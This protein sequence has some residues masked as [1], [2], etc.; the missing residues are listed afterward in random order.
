[1]WLLCTPHLTE[2]YWWWFYDTVCYRKIFDVILWRVFKT[3]FTH[4]NGP[5]DMNGHALWQSKIKVF[6]VVIDPVGGSDCRTTVR[7]HYV[8]FGFGLPSGLTWN[9]F[10]FLI[11]K[12]NT[13]N[14]KGKASEPTTI[15]NISPGVIPRFWAHRFGSCREDDVDCNDRL[16]NSTASTAS[17]C[18]CVSSS[19]PA[20]IQTTTPVTAQHPHNPC[21]YEHVCNFLTLWH[22][23]P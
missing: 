12:E 19:A 3:R 21:I 2:H 4:M 20:R 23:M 15:I 6:H 18:V 5:Y 7:M 17:C 8:L 16:V 13:A 10:L 11:T 9:S 14:I 22:C 1:M